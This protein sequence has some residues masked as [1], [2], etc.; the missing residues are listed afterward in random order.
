M[1]V[2]QYETAIDPAYLK[3]MLTGGTGQ[4]SQQPDQRIALRRPGTDV[5]ATRAFQLTSATLPYDAYT[6]SPVHRFYQMWQQRD[7]A[8]SASTAANPAAAATTCFPGSKRRSGPART[9]RPQ[10]AGFNN[11]STGE[12]S[13][14]MGFYN[15]Q[16]GDAPYL[17]QLADKY[18]MSDNY[19][20][21][22][23]G[24]T[25]ANH[26][27]LGAGDAI[28]FSDGA[29]H[30]A[31]PP[32]YGVN[33]TSPGTPLVGNASALS[34]IENPNPQPGTNNYYIED[35]Y[36]GGSGSPTATTPNA[37]YGGGSYSD[38]S[39]AAQPGVGAIR[40]LP[41]RDQGRRALRGGSLLPAQQLQSGLFRRRHERLRRRQRQELRL[42]RPAVD[43]ANDR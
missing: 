14:S 43:A 23:N 1:K 21:A 34:E 6:A 24:G 36:G 5:P 16:A 29:G 38:C 30:A 7:C 9:A 33:P 10:P 15:V 3:Y 39:D 18:T 8:P 37:N 22:V 40:E 2:A 4:P 13:T 19:H 11:M 26:L 27:M 32:N 25:G 28:W 42:H 12:G 20:Q 17:K 41:Q 31:V 35:G